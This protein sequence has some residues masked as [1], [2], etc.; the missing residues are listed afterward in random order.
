MTSFRSIALAVCLVA[1]SA[2]PA[3]AQTAVP[4]QA[5]ATSGTAA[6]EAPL[7]DAG[8]KKAAPEPRAHHRAHRHLHAK[9]AVS[10]TPP[11]HAGQ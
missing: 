5:P 3:L 2:L 10:A 6:A 1:S 8:I 9:S 11:A 4:D 7:P